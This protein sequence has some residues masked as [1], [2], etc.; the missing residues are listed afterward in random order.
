LIQKEEVSKLKGK[1][2]MWNTVDGRRTVR[3]KDQLLVN[4]QCCLNYYSQTKTQDTISMLN[5]H[6]NIAKLSNNIF[7][8]ADLLP[9]T[10]PIPALSGAHLQDGLNL[11]SQ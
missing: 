5:N 2:V 6:T 10:P 7:Q 1:K 3:K 8:R 4:I 9:E 11:I